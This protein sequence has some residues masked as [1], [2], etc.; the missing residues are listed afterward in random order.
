MTVPTIEHANKAIE[1][2][3]TQFKESTN[4]IAYIRTLLAESD[5]LESVIQSII[6]ERALDT[7]VGKQLDIIG[8]IVG[9][10]R[11][12]VDATA[13][14]YF[15]FVGPVQSNPFGTLGNPTIGGRFIAVGEPITGF[16]EL[17]DEEYRFYIRAKIIKN[18]TLS[19][20]E[21]IIFQMTFVL[22]VTETQPQPAVVLAEG[23]AAYTVSIGIPVSQNILTLLRTESLIAKTAGVSFNYQTYFDANDF[24]GF[25]GV[26]NAGGFGSTFSGGGSPMGTL[27]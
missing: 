26:P 22:G 7:A 24:F 17:N 13:F 10:S 1:R 15:G 23:N 25:S 21:D 20:P 14:S 19:T 18:N 3:A 4:L 11:E 5:T 9:Q 2:L 16:R 12:V 6:T 27:I 8:E